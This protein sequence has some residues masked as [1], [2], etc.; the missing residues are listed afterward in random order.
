MEREK[1]MPNGSA[2]FAHEVV[3]LY[4][5]TMGNWSYPIITASAFSIMF[6][7]SIAVFDGYARSLEQTTQLI[8]QRKKDE[9]SKINLYI[10]SLIAV[11][12]GAFLIIWKFGD[13]L[14]QLVDLATTIS[15][16]IAPIIAVV[17]FRLVSIKYI[18]RDCT[19]PLWLQLLSWV[20]I[21]FLTGFSIFYI[22]T[23]FS[24]WVNS[25]F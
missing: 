16:L 20:G 23:N 8:L 15:F 13:S 21:I 19:P 5:A 2:A 9:G 11:M 7:T 17:N 1:T 18:S 22:N 25:L 4:T 3:N 6:G 12:L 10:L 24:A 14:K